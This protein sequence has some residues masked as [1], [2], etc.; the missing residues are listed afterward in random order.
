MIRI[1][2]VLLVLVAAPLRAEVDIEEVTSP[3]GITAWLV[4][5]DSI[6]FTALELRFRGG[7]SLDEEGRRGAVNLMTGLIEE[8]AG[9]LT[10]QEFQATR[11]SLAASFEFDAYDDAVSIGARFLTE[12]RDDAVALLKSALT[13]PRFDEDAI[14]R[15]R[16][17]VIAGLRSEEKD[18]DEIA[19]DTFALEAF[20][21]HPYG[22]NERGTLESVAALTRDD[23]VTAHRNVLARDR[24]YVSAVGDITPEQRG[25]LTDALHGALP[26]SGAPMP[27]TVP[28]GIEGG[29]TVVPFDTPQSSIIFGH[30]GMERHD[31]DFFPAFILNTILGGTN[32]ETRL[33]QEVRVNRGLTYGI[34]TFLVPKDHAALYLGSVATSNDRV[35]ET[36]EVVRD[37]WRRMAEEGVTPEELQTA[38]TYLTGA[39][40][41]RFDGNGPIASMLVGMQIQGLPIDYVNTRNDQVMAVTLEDINRVAGEL[42]DPDAL[43]FTVVG[44]PE[45]VETTN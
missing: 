44:Q 7:T 9:D 29:V 34:Y 13:D 32:F 43:H 16:A 8:G 10:A 28:V 23:I 17:Q 25:T 45:E 20:G 30:E 6:P 33:M 22:T 2:S 36:I 4:Q 21:A 38:K 3:G 15:V 39:Y 26:E 41:L 18:P 5:E 14:E 35:A 27:E 37:E 42:L 1:L 12:N 24:V 19:Q 11:E 31:D 40:P